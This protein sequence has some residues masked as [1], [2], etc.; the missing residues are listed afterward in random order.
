MVKCATVS[1]LL[2]SFAFMAP[3]AAVAGEPKKDD[4]LN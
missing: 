1:L 4:N 3:A 2:L